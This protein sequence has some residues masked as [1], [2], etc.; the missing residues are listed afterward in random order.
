MQHNLQCDVLSC[1]WIS[2]SL[3]YF[4]GAY[5]KRWLGLSPMCRYSV[6][7]PSSYF[8]Y[9]SFCFQPFA[10]CWPKASG[11]SYE[12]AVGFFFFSIP[13][14]VVRR[15]QEVGLWVLEPH[16]SSS[17]LFSFFII[18]KLRFQ[19]IISFNW[20]DTKTSQN[21]SLVTLCPDSWAAE[22]EETPPHLLWASC[23]DICPICGPCHHKGSRPPLDITMQSQISSWLLM[24]C[25]CLLQ[26]GFYSVLD[27]NM[28][29]ALYTHAA[30]LFSCHAVQRGYT[31]PIHVPHSVWLGGIPFCCCIQAK[32]QKQ[33]KKSLHQD[34][35]SFGSDM[36]TTLIPVQRSWSFVMIYGHFFFC[37]SGWGAGGIILKLK[38]EG[39]YSVCFYVHVLTESAQL[40]TCISALYQIIWLCLFRRK[41]IRPQKV[42][43]KMCWLINY[44]TVYHF[45][46]TT[47]YRLVIYKPE[48]AHKRTSTKMKCMY[49]ACLCSCLCLQH[50]R[51]GIHCVLYFI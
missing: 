7:P 46:A 27:T 19:I 5:Y 26:H 43:E 8:F 4:P 36:F 29:A 10:L 47:S 1:W 41:G 38:V 31:G 18:C 37:L 17:F 20:L 15:I 16:S 22:I 34:A 44:C 39:L 11:Q 14:K 25:A 33:N 48:L 3:P 12:L 32:K 13:S 24:G 23:A 49:I 30:V 28:A 21:I 35:V 50:S 40:C 2:L 9:L 51:S 6:S 45:S 42:N